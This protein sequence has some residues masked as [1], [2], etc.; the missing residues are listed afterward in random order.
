MATKKSKRSPVDNTLVKRVK[1]TGCNESFITLMERHEKLFYKICQLYIPIAES[2]GLRKEDIFEEKKYVLFKAINSYKINKKTKFSTWFGNC[3]K[4][5]CLTFLNS[6][7]KLV[8]MEDDAIELCIAN[9]SKEEYHDQTDLKNNKDYVFEILRQLK[10]KRISK[11]F[12][13]RYFDD[14]KRSNKPTWSR[15]ASKINTS[16]QTAIN[17]HQRGVKILHKKLKSIDYIDKI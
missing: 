16:T 10:D 5:F 13:L 17:L 3:T 1:A 7:S 15:I 2:K 9:K 6:N 4:Y 8:D 11:V 12:K 14:D